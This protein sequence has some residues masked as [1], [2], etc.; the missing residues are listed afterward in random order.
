MM[1]AACGAILAVVVSCTVNVS[2]QDMAAAEQAV[3]QA[4]LL[5]YKA[6][7]AQDIE[8]LERVVADELSYCHTSGAVEDKAS[9][10]NTV[11]SGRLTWLSMVPEDMQVHVYGNAA[12]IAGRLRETIQSAGRSEPR[13]LVLR[14]IEV[15]VRRDG[16]WQMAAFQAAPMSAQPR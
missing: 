2:A 9:Y 6:Q 10:L 13:A 3:R 7:M 1:R 15:F 4:Q 11:R 5:R 16:R 8:T 12:V 14:T